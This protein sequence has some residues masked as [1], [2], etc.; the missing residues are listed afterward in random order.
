MHSL[1]NDCTDASW[2][3]GGTQ[4]AA[5]CY[6]LRH[7]CARLWT[8]TM[9]VPYP[10]YALPPRCAAGDGCGTLLGFGGCGHPCC[11]CGVTSQQAR[12]AAVSQ[13]LAETFNMRCLHAMLPR[14]SNCTF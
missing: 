8:G 14:S 7:D 1:F 3:T 12:A 10:L 5:A 11:G 9:Y 4:A 6:C 13:Q 2:H